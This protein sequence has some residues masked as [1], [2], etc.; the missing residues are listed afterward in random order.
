LDTDAFDDNEHSLSD[1]SYEDIDDS[2]HQQPS[3]DPDGD[4]GADEGPEYK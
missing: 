1:D 4:E 3:H 2:E